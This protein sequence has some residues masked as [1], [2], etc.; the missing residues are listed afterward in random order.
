MWASLL[1]AAA[2]MFGGE[3]RSLPIVGGQTR[4]WQTLQV[5]EGRDHS[6]VTRS[7]PLRLGN[8]EYQ[9]SL[10]FGDRNAI[11]LRSNR[12]IARIGKAALHTGR[13]AH[14]LIN[15]QTRLEAGKYVVDNRVSRSLF[16]L[17]LAEL[18]SSP[19]ARLRIND[20]DYPLP[21]QDFGVAVGNMMTCSRTLTGGHWGR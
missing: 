1:W 5:V 4:N 13:G 14:A 9:V 17:V 19:Q 6:C 7:V 10:S 3:D 12:P 21:M 15:L 2:A 11:A 18:R 16:R 8:T 20:V